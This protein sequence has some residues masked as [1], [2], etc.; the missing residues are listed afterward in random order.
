MGTIKRSY[1][2][3]RPQEVTPGTARAVDRIDTASQDTD[4]LVRRCTAEALSRRYTDAI[5]GLSD[6][7]RAAV[8]KKK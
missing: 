7:I 1:Y 3:E 5:I 4:P 8:R 6:L 2:S